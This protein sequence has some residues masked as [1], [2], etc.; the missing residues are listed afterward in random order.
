M[1]T[2]TRT[3]TETAEG[4]SINMTPMLDVVFIL[5]IFFV[6]TAS[7]IREF[8]VSVSRPSLENI[9]TTNAVV[10]PVA[11]GPNDAVWIDR[12]IIDPAAL[13]AN[14]LSIRAENT[15]VVV[16]I[17]A[18]PESTT[19]TFVRVVD[20]ARAAGIDNVAIER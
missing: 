7:F 20:A 5:L 19:D 9:P 12:R 18:A 4:D 17:A 14:F 15:K 8:G 3:D 11:I 10:V 6:V 2:F 13:H 16:S 1:R